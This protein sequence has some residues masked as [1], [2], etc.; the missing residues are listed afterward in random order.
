L[1]PLTRVT[2]TV[3]VTPSVPLVLIAGRSR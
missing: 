1:T 3:V 2:P